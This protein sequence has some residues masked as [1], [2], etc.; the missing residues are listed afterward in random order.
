MGSRV[1][2]H[3]T[4]IARAISKAK[5]CAPS[6]PALPIASLLCATFLCYFAHAGALPDAAATSDGDR[7]IPEIVVTARKV[8]ENIQSIP[9]SISA[10]DSLTLSA[11][12]LITLDDLN[13]HVS[14]LNITQRADNTPDVV[15][16]GVGSY[17]VVQGVGFY[18]N[19]VQQFD[20]QSARPMDIERIEVLKGPQG[21]LFGG[22]N[23]GG[24][25]KYVTKSPTHALTGEGSIE[26]GSFNQQ[27]VDGVVSGPIVPD[28]LL[29]RLSV[30][31]DRSDGYLS[32]PTLGKTLPDSN[33]TGGR[34]TLEYPGDLTKITFYLSGD[35]ID[36]ENMNLY[37]TPPDDHTYSLIYKG[38]VDGTTPSYRRNLYAPT[39]AI[40]HYFGDITFNSITSYFHSS[41]TSIANFDKGAFPSAGLLLFGPPVPDPS[42]PL[43]PLYCCQAFEN[44]QQDFGKSI[45]SQEFRL[46]SSASSSF[47]WLAGAFIQRIDSNAL[48]TQSLGMN[49]TPGNPAGVIPLLPGALAPIPVSDVEYQHVNRDYAIFGN[50]SYD[51]RNWT[52]EAGARISHFD[53]TMT[54]T[55]AS[56]Q[57]CDG[58]VKGNAVLLPTGSISYH[59]TQDAMAYV[60]VA[61][62]DE[63][64][65]LADNPAGFGAP[66]Q[67][68]PFKTEYALSYEA[69]VKSS[70][71]DR[72][73]TLNVAGFYID[74]I[75][76]LFEVGKVST[77]GIFTYTSNVGSSRNYGFEVEA[78]ARLPANFT[79]TAGV[80]VTEAIFGSGVYNDGYNNPVNLLGTTA[81]NTPAYQGALAV[82]WRHT[83]SDELA[84]SAR[85]DSRFV[86]RSYWDVGGCSA[87]SPGCPHEGSR[88]KQ[89][90]YQIVNAGMSLDLGKHWS[91]G[92]HLMN[93]F[94][95]RYNTFYADGSETGAPYNIAGTNRPRQWFISVHARY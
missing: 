71:F 45:W 84:L 79:V 42:S 23:V 78:E 95:E 30:F 43:Y 56:C 36:T 44:Y 17:G 50:A 86:G 15:L 13:S 74:Y 85:I 76:R 40:V 39:L 61:R 81:P 62:G 67:V 46:S 25:I 21:T 65:D 75:N 26:Y 93:V 69:G 9:E 19:D 37:Y 38:G 89:T 60:T 31:N 51:L 52:F 66:N 35:H 4:T 10:I 64:G 94:D 47:R 2:N 1:V 73:L 57:P 6:R 82:D 53:N 28:Q 5:R 92:A 24:A 34:L 33:E 22:S 91:A 11:A 80:G 48:Q 8:G 49:S 16:R 59:I 88:F 7:T 63:E 58:R 54:D 12:H 77:G 68:I 70:L 72:R 20:G 83:L 14:N 32:D 87:L 27:T 18:I 3:R 41:V 55:T 90:A 29:A